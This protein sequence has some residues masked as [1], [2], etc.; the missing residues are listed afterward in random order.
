MAPTIGMS[1]PIETKMSETPP[2]NIYSAKFCGLE[3]DTSSE[4]ATLE[5][6]LEDFGRIGVVLTQAGLDSLYQHILSEG[7]AGHLA[8]ELRSGN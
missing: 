4:I 6:D 8:F 7:A 1:Q 3:A 5:F 2:L